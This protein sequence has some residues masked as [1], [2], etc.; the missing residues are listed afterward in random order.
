MQSNYLAFTAELFWWFE[1]VKP[2]FVQP[3]TARP[4]GGSALR[5]QPHPRRVLIGVRTFSGLKPGVRWF[6]ARDGGRE[7]REVEGPL[8]VRPRGWGASLS[9]RVRS[10]L[11][12]SFTPARLWSL[13]DSGFSTL[14]PRTHSDL[15]L[16][17]NLPLEFAIKL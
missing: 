14:A 5:F 6:P 9:L 11:S 8:R 16:G 17:F 4:H 2:S 10:L 15:W 3:R 12:A 13:F 1:V 7:S